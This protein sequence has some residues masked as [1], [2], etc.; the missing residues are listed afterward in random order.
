MSPYKDNIDSLISKYSPF[1]SSDNDDKKTEMNKV[2][3]IKK[4]PEI[5]KILYEKE[6]TDSRRAFL[7]ES[8]RK[9]NESMNRILVII[10]I[11]L[12]VCFLLI[13]LYYL[14]YPMLPN[15]LIIIASIIVISIAI[16]LAYRQYFDSITRWKM[17]FDIY[18]IPP[19]L[20][21]DT[22][23]ISN[24]SA[25][26]SDFGSSLFSGMCM[27]ASCCSQGTS[28]DSITGRCTLIVPTTPLRKT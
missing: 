12:F 16:I 6:T 10:L 23:N 13:I 2:V 9:W 11:A 8:V 24:N 19:P 3:D 17:D 22:E 27:N 7:E 21:K 26:V 5:G 25:V 18:K 14:L 15:F 28:W 4:N 1:F 20:I